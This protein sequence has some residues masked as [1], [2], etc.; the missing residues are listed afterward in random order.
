[1]KYMLLIC[2]DPT[3]LGSPAGQAMIP[4]ILAKHTKLAEEFNA[5]GVQWS[6]ARLQGADAAT[7]VRTDG[8]QQTLHDGPFAE[9]KEQL[10]GYYLIEAPDLDAAIAWAKKIPMPGR[11]S[12]EVRPI[13]GM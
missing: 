13:M 7:T 1:M 5:A 9:T 4:D 2:S 10:G 12:V 11:G 8:G 3:L 6:G